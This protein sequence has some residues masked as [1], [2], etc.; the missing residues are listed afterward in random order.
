MTLEQMIE[1]VLDAEDVKFWN[2]WRSRFP[3]WEPNLSGMSLSYRDLRGINLADADLRSTDLEGT[4]LASRGR[5]PEIMN[6]IYDVHTTWPAGVEPETDGGLLMCVEVEDGSPQV[7]VSYAE[8]DRE[9]ALQIADDLR[10]AGVR[11]FEAS[12]SIRLG[13]RW[14][15]EIEDALRTVR[16]LVAVCSPDSI[17]K[18]WLLF[19]SGGAWGRDIPVVPA[20][21]DDSLRPRLPAGL[22]A[23]QAHSIATEPVRR[24]FVREL[25]D[26]L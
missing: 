22:S 10:D 19:E 25:A 26:S 9:L 5:R 3:E 16:A 14:L 17:S 6:A 4:E 2:Q 15:D 18:P 7:F 13:T 24:K 21:S 12:E 1:S 11:V 8:A 23:F 20:L